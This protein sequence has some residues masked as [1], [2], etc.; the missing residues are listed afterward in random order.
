[1]KLMIFRLTHKNTRNLASSRWRYLAQ[2]LG[3]TSYSYLSLSL[4]NI[5]V[6]YLEG[7]S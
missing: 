7:I 2:E 1:M 4:L 3:T 6:S 5:S